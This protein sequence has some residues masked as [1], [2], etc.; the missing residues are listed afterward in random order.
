L[1]R[2]TIAVLALLVVAC[3]IGEAT[4]TTGEATTTSS[5]T[6]TE[7]GTSPTE[8]GGIDALI[9]A[10]R[11]EGT[12]NTI[13]L[14]HDY[15]N[16]GGVIEG[17][18]S[19]YG[20]EV[21]E[22]APD[23]GPADGLEAIRVSQ[24]STGAQSPDVVDIGLTL[25]PEAQAEGLLQRYQ[26]EGWD[27]IP[28]HAKDPNGFWY[29]GYYGVLAF[30][31][32][33]DS[34]S[35]VPADWSDLLDPQFQ[36]M[37]ALAGDPRV[38]NQAIFTVFAASLANGGSL[39]DAQPGLEYFAQLN[40]VGNLA[41]VIADSATVASGETPVAIRWTYNALPNRDANA[42]EAVI[43]VVVPESGRLAFVYVQAISAF[44]P[45]P[46]AA[47]LWMEYLYSDEGQLGWLEG[48][49]IPIRYDD[50]VEGRVIPGDLASRLPDSSGT[51]FPSVDQA[52]VAKDLIAAN[53]EA[54][55]G[56]DPEG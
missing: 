53:W 38:S 12:L 37:V 33:A 10:A 51:A 44:A 49:C 40:D 21:N 4:P 6:T 34:A 56:V 52:R 42:T 13:G 22:L 17:F 7:G 16:Y 29:G 20:I 31:V 18:K 48:Y 1:K 28:D 55:V 47:K 39:D 54:V 46:N 8:V 23:A 2:T 5:A 3:R 15:C 43:E 36:G 26:V 30:D 45:H 35:S 50:L 27:S 25:A 32:N 24:G 14:P 41:P 11:A 9:G 19:K